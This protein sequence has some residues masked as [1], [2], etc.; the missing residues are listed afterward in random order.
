MADDNQTLLAGGVGTAFTVVLFVVYRFVVP[1]FNAA[2]HKR[3]R[4]VCC[5]KSCVTS[6]D[7]ENTTPTATAAAATTSSDTPAR[8]G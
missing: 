4:S 7:V 2:N 5:G 1:L 3:V 6:V 8:G